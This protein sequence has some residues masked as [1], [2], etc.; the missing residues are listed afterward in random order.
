MWAQ[1]KLLPLGQATNLISA[2]AGA[3]AAAEH[4]QAVASASAHAASLP[5]DRP[6]PR[7]LFVAR[8]GR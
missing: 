8:D 5:N 7:N 6:I 2:V 3:A 1:A 4:A